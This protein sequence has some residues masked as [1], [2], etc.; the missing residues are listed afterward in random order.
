M[1][2]SIHSGSNILTF[3]TLVGTTV[4]CLGLLGVMFNSWEGNGSSFIAAIAMGLVW[5]VAI[6]C[7]TYG[8]STLKV[9]ISIIAP[10]TNSNVLVVIALSS[11]VFKENQNLDLKNLIGGAFLIII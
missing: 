9:P 11:L 7:M 6:G 10:I 3:L 2:F 5:S 1:K 8:I 4:G